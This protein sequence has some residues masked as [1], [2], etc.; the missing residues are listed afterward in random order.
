MVFQEALKNVHVYADQ[1]DPSVDVIIRFQT[2]YGEGS[3]SL[4][5]KKFFK[6][7]A[8]IMMTVKRAWSYACK[9]RPERET[10]ITSIEVRPAR[11][12]TQKTL[13]TA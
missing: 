3:A 6:N 4:T 8:E 1:N 13:K 2:S 10:A 7:Q 12:I 9:S 5:A 11:D